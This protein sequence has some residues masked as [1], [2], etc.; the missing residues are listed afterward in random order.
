MD[1]KISTGTNSLLLGA[2]Y[3]QGR[4]EGSNTFYYISVLFDVIKNVN[5]P[6]VNVTVNPNNNTQQRVTMTPIIRAGFNIGLFP[7]RGK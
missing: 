7:R 3:A 2:G 4:S 5:S 6:Y 1:G